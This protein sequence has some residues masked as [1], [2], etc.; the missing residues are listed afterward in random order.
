MNEEE[1]VALVDARI[2]ER[3]AKHAADLAKQHE[4]PPD[5]D[6]YRTPPPNREFEAELLK[7]LDAEK[8]DVGKATE[9]VFQLISSSAPAQ[10]LTQLFKEWRHPEFGPYTVGLLK[11]YISNLKD[12]R[13]RDA[14]REREI[15]GV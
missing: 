8:G 1:L 5:P 9:R 14:R 6:I 13:E 11:L 4:R 2:A 15:A 7:A 3:D 12:K 10:P